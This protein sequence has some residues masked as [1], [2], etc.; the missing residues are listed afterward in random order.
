MPRTKPCHVPFPWA[1]WV[2]CLAYWCVIVSRLQ[3]LS[4]ATDDNLIDLGPGSPAVMSP[5]ISSTPPSSLPASV[6]PT[7]S[8]SPA[9][10]ASQLAGLGESLP[11]LIICISCM[12]APIIII[13]TLSDKWQSCV[14]SDIGAD[15][16]S[17]TLSSLS[18][19]QPLSD[20]FDMFA[21]TRTG[22][23]ADQRK[24]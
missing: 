14:F 16:V 6:A 12:L 18:R 19:C 1:M 24:K 8:A 20:D 23:L 3:V 2:C 13:V 5:R 15:S 7:H 4:E 17:G 21:Q 11:L 9:T 22:T 10:L